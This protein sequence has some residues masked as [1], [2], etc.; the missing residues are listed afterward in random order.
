MTSL[1]RV[2]R[3]FYVSSCGVAVEGVLTS[4]QVRMTAVTTT[5]A[6]IATGTKT[7]ETQDQNQEPTRQRRMMKA[8]AAPAG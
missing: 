4:S 7:A 5:A 2:F 1:V 6:M 8:L 3:E